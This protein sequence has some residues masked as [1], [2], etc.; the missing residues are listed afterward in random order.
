MADPPLL[1]TGGVHQPYTPRLIV[2]VATQGGV[3]GVGETYGDGGYLDLAQPLAQALLGRSV[4]DLNG[5]FVSLAAMT[6]V[7]A[8]LPNLGHG[9]DSHYPWQTE[10]V[11][12]GRH[13]FREG[14]LAVSDAPGL[15]VE[16]DRD[17]LAALHKRWLEDDGTL[18]ER[19]DAAAIRVADPDW[20]APSVPRW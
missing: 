18:R 1:N 10:G 7:A 15:G 14:R 9:C 5:L 8:T 16:L 17:A 13:V 20:A 19:D 3:T 6:Q 4:S 12:T 11:I 2:E